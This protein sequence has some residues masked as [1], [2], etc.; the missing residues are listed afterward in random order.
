MASY[1]LAISLLLEFG[2]IFGNAPQSWQDPGLA[3]EAFIEFLYLEATT[4]KRAYDCLS[5]FTFFF[6]RVQWIFESM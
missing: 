5:A 4:F 3:V 6:P 2:T 1:V